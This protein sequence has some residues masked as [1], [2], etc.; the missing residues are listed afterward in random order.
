MPCVWG[1]H[2]SK[3]GRFYS[4]A[5]NVDRHWTQL[6]GDLLLTVYWYGN[7]FLN[8]KKYPVLK[9]EILCKPTILH[10]H[11]IY[12]SNAPP[13][14][15]LNLRKKF[16]YS[17]CLHKNKTCLFPHVNYFM[18]RKTHLLNFVISL[19]NYKLFHKYIHLN[20]K[21]KWNK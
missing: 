10:I 9:L 14:F 20:K 6:R 1:F 11:T 16:F 15:S 7:I 5:Q 3:N 12:L 17:I 18:Y 2:I 13:F 21:L 4:I 19:G 8:W